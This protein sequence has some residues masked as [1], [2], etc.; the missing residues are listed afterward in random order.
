MFEKIIG[1]LQDPR[2]WRRPLTIAVC[3]TILIVGYLSVMCLIT[4]T[5][6]RNEGAEKEP[7]LSQQFNS[8]VAFYGQLRQSVA[9]QLSVSRE[10]SN[11]MDAILS[12]AVKGRYDMPGQPG[13]VDRQAVFSAIKEAY[14]DTSGLNIYDRVLENIQAGRQHFANQQVQLQDMVR[15]YKTWC[16]T[17]S[18]FH[19]YWVKKLGFPRNNLVAK[20]GDKEYHGQAAL[21]KMSQVII[22]QD[23]IQIFRTGVDKPMTPGK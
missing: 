17:G 1:T 14:P 23:T 18:L 13:V 9:D 21:D 3:V 7:A 11:A 10:K 19:P 6:V 4:Y 12:D 8:T 5:T 2:F 20:I 15:D 16:T 22:D